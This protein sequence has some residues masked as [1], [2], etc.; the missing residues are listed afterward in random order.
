MSGSPA[1]Y[2]FALLRV[3]PRVHLGAFFNVGVILH[4][5]TS[6]FIGMRVLD[7]VAHLSRLADGLDVQLLMA[8]LQ[9][10]QEISAGDPAGGPLALLP[11]SERFHWLTAP[12]SDIFQSSPVHE[13]VCVDPAAALDR[14]F[15]ETLRPV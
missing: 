1:V 8:Y 2:H 6:E 5:R 15:Q 7:D 9:R 13:G 12:R 4:A 14:I 10:F 11:P 3:V